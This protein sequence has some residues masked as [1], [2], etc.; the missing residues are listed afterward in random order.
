MKEITS[1]VSF[2]SLEILKAVASGRTSTEQCLGRNWHCQ[3]KADETHGVSNR[4]NHMEKKV[5]PHLASPLQFEFLSSVV[6]HMLLLPRSLSDPIVSA[7]IMKNL[8]LH[9]K[10][11]LCFHSSVQRRVLSSLPPYHTMKVFSASSSAG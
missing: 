6:S 3:G 11:W 8:I 5:S 1:M 10:S 2:M 7:D 4:Q 9:Y